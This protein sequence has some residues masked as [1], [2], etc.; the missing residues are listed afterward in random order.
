MPRKTNDPIPLIGAKPKAAPP[1]Q[2][3]LPIMQYVVAESG[4][5]LLTRV[6]DP[7]ASMT[8]L[9]PAG[10]M[11]ELAGEWLEKQQAKVTDLATIAQINKSRN[12]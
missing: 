2:A 11:R 12:D 10:M 1:Q 4:D 6:A 7:G 8:W 9:V 3:Q 5:V